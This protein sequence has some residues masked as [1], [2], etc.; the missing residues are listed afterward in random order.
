MER[1]HKLSLGGSYPGNP[2][3]MF[4]AIDH[5]GILQ[6]VNVGREFTLQ[7]KSEDFEEVAKSLKKLGVDNINILEWK[8]FG[9][10]IA[11]SGSSP[12]EEAM[13]NVSLIPSALG[14]GL[15]PMSVSHKVELDKKLYIKMLANIEAILSDAGVTDALYAMQVDKKSEKEE[16]LEAV[17][18]ATL[19]ALFNSGGVVS[20]E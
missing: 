16:Y 4:R 20:I 10:T 6:F 7:I 8:K 17:R 13:V 19:N 9:T 18:D 11:S 2:S 5:G 1:G 15:K 14:T 3:D 12:D